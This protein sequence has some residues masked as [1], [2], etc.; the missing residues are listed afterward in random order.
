MQRGFRPEMSVTNSAF[1]LIN[2][3]MSIIT[4]LSSFCSI[5]R[6][7]AFFMDYAVVIGHGD[8]NLLKWQH[9]RGKWVC[10]FWFDFD[11]PPIHLPL[12]PLPTCNLWFDFNWELRSLT[13]EHSFL[14]DTPYW[15]EW[16]LMV[17]CCGGS[18]GVCDIA[19][20]SRASSHTST[21]LRERQ[22]QARHYFGPRESIKVPEQ[23]GPSCSHWAPNNESH[24]AHTK[25]YTATDTTC[26]L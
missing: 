6:F 13:I 15:S 2:S 22:T 9:L 19:N 18:D 4:V 25:V 7:A 21:A 11:F 26:A 16:Q 5:Y 20:M 23:R 17:C 12:P 24:S 3:S 1:A 14:S 10:V 8:M